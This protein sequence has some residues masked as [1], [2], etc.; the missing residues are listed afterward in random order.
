[1]G[2]HD[3]AWLT[4]DETHVREEK[5]G[6]ALSRRGCGGGRAQAAAAAAAGE[7]WPQ[8]RVEAS[9]FARVLQDIEDRCL[10]CV[11]RVLQGE[12][13]PARPWQQDG[14]LVYYC[15][16][17]DIWAGVGC[18]AAAAAVKQPAAVRLCERGDA[19]G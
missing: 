13:W 5:A 3:A 15:C 17:E 8:G 9:V 2:Q 16:V 19:Q 6:E 10:D 11:R 4:G 12:G 7:A 1:M 14:L 18:A